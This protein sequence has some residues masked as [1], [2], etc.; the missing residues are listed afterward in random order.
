MQPRCRSHGPG[1]A[2]DVLGTPN[3]LTTGVSGLT[4]GAYTYKITA[5]DSNG[6]TASATTTVTAAAVAAAAYTTN[7]NFNAT[8]QNVS[9][10]LDVSSAGTNTTVYT[11]TI[12]NGVTLSSVATANWFWN[13]GSTSNTNNTSYTGSSTV[14]P[15][16][17]GQ[18]AWFLYTNIVYDK[19][20][21]KAVLLF[22]GCVVG[23]TYSMQIYSAIDAAYQPGD[24]F[25]I[26]VNGGTDQQPNAT[27]NASTLITFSNISPDSSGRIWISTG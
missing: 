6:V 13:N 5:T 22:T 26:S 9:N 15:I 2:G 8:P 11:A 14:V 18:S 16:A 3:A 27:A 1:P 12:G 25:L 10:W 24:N 20:L 7:L 23:G 19:T 21:P 4:T 17:V